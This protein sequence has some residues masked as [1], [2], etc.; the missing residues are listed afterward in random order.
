[1]R[2]ARALGPV[3]VAAHE[4]QLSGGI[5]HERRVSSSSFSMAIPV[6]DWWLAP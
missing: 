1:M 6:A 3:Q 2:L 4:R 5:A